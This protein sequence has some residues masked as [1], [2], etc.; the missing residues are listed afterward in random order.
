[1]GHRR[2][3]PRPRAGF[4]GCAPLGASTEAPAAS[5]EHA[6]RPG[7]Y[8]L[9]QDPER[10]FAA[11]RQLVARVARR[12]RGRASANDDCLSVG[13][14]AI[15]EASRAYHPEMR[16]PFDAFAAVVVRR[17]LIDHY[18]RERRVCEIPLSAFEREEEDG[19]VWCPP[20]NTAAIDAH[21]RTREAGETRDEVDDFVCLIGRHGI[22]LQDVFRQCPRHR[23]AR[24]RAI[25]VARRLVADPARAERLRH[26]GSVPLR[27]MEEAGRPVG[28]GR[29]TLERRR[30]YILAVALM[31]AEGFPRLEAH[32]PA[33]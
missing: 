12:V 16:L 6:A 29:K 8:A 4:T 5:R 25:A 3:A 20:E 32:L 10:T 19:T 24:G 9:V 27:Q 15:L 30:R 11:H 26:S 17:R 1:V 23:D 22:T 14:S 31:L 18:R 2:A 33:G 28:V 21:R 13:L 7:W